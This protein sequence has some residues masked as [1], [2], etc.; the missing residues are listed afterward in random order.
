[1]ARQDGEPAF[2]RHQAVVLGLLV[3]GLGT[4]GLDDRLHADSILQAVGGRP[5]S[6]AL[7]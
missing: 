1:M 4:R 6:T 2:Q 5:A 3:L 7:R